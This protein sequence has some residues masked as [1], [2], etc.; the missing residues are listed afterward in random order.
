MVKN[1]DKEMNNISINL[2]NY[3]SLAKWTPNLGDVVVYHGW[4]THWFGV[5]N[6]IDG[7]TIHIVKAGIPLLLFTMDDIDMPKNTVKIGINK[8]KRSTGGKYSISQ[9]IAGSSMWYI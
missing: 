1:T 4:L 9:T 7:G 2:I 6:A 3:N 5:V 8:I